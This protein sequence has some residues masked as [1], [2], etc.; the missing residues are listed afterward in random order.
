MCINPGIMA[1][2]F[3]STRSA[4]GITL[5]IILFAPWCFGQQPECILKKE[6]E[7]IKVY[8]CKTE[9]EKFKSI[10]AEFELENISAQELSSFV[11][12]V[13]TYTTW[14]YNT[15]EAEKLSSPKTDGMVYRAIVDAPWPVENREL[16]LS[17]KAVE[18]TTHTS[19]YVNS[20]SYDQ[21]T[22]KG[23]VRVPYVSAYWKLISKGSALQVYYTLKIDPGGLVPAWLANIA[24][25]EGPYISFKNLKAQLLK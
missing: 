15:I 9:N 25:A 20:V 24:M 22:P 6:S 21:P 11:L 5:I 10:R 2:L 17:I 1:L 4:G 19:I 18:E 3:K 12:N 13:N 16:V 23:M 14:Q 7:G 8:T